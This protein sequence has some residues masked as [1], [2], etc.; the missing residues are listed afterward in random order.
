VSYLV[1]TNVLSE[2]TR[3]KPAPSVVAWFEDVG[4]EAL[5]LSVLMV[6]TPLSLSED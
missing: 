5:H 3:P 6:E 4:D 2:L 1:D